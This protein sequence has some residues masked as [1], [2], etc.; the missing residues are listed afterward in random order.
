MTMFGLDRETVEAALAAVAGAAGPAD[1]QG[2]E[3]GDV[4]SDAAGT[5]AHFARVAWSVIAE[6]GDAA[7]SLV[8]SSL[9]PAAA[10]TALVRGWSAERVAASVQEALP[11]RGEPGPELREAL[12]DA[13][14][15]WSP[16]V[17]SEPALRALRLAAHCGASLVL[18]GD[19]RWPLTLD[20]LGSHAPLVLWC[21]GDLGAG[22]FARS[23]SLVGA[24]A[25]SGYGEHVALEAAAGLVDRGF[26][27]VSG[28]AYGIDTAAHRAA[29]ASSGLTVAFLAGGVDRYYPSGN[30]DL[31]ERIRGSGAV[32]S[33]VPCGTAP[34]K[35]RFLQRN[36]L[37]AAASR[38]TI[39]IEAGWR[40]GSLN[41][42]AHAGTLGRPVGAVPG[43]VT[44][45]A[46]AGCHRLIREFAATCVCDAGQMAEL[47][48]MPTGNDA[49]SDA[50][51][52]RRGGAEVRVLDALS[53]RSARTVYELAERTGLSEAATRGTL[54]TLGLDGAARETAGGWIAA[55]LP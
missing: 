3:Q 25:A 42:A 28:A 40:S 36:R 6:P 53:S 15:R 55:S 29:L 26:T 19:P 44:S 48:G 49:E 7:A 16:R 47:A 45:P 46:S 24:R 54:G 18:P 17:K 50:V 1:E 14:K 10:L 8:V 11:D 32:V 30:H 34:T 27:I 4:P 21:R 35:W 23:I 41:T 12:R 39:V 13:L 43:A 31:L 9:G 51:D 2:G 52:Q 5:E 38:A 37:I 20:D 33:E 22:T